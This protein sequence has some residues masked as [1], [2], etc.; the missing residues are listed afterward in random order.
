MLVLTR[1]KEQKIKIGKDIVITVLKIQGNQV[2][3]GIE[4]PKETQIIRDEL[5]DASTEV[6]AFSESS[7][8]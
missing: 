1:K 6:N 5:V 3:V 2:S 8:T 7:F 4:A